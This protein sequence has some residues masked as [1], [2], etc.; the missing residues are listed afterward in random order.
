MKPEQFAQRMKHVA[1]EIREPAGLMQKI[2]LGAEAESK[3]QASSGP[4]KAVRTGTWRRSITGRVLT[5]QKGVVG[6]NLSYGPF[7]HEGTK[8]MR[9][10]PAIYDGIQAARPKI[11]ELAHRYGVE[12]FDRVGGS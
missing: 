11:V 4:D 12:V 10:R 6:S 9:A 7:V 3:R 5:A 8:H 2:V 1:Q